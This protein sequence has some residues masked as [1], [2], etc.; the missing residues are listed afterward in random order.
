MT[1]IDK[2]K[3]KATYIV[4]LAEL[5]KLSN[6]KEGD[7][8]IFHA[9]RQIYLLFIFNDF[10][11]S[12]TNLAR[13]VLFFVPFTGILSG[14]CEGRISDSIALINLSH[15]RFRATRERHCLFNLSPTEF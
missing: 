11:P 15:R 3:V 6:L 1:S 10:Q 12:K 7:H 8:W 14:T 2:L 13:H 4:V 9:A 5:V